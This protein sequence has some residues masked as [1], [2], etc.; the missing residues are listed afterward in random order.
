MRSAS[1]T[2]AAAIEIDALPM[3][4][5][6]RTSFATANVRWNRRFSTSPSEPADFRR[7]HRLLHLAQDLRLAQHHRVEPARDAERVRHRLVARQRVD[8][9]RERVRAA[10]CGSR[11]SQ[12]ATGGGSPPAK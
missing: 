6:V 11:A 1:F 8:V 7:A 4:V 2:A 3:S 5:C 12:R 9:G 10:S